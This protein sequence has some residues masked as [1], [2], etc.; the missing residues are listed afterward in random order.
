[1]PQRSQQH[2]HA[3][4]GKAALQTAAE[5]PGA[6]PGWLWRAPEEPPHPQVSTCMP[7]CPSQL[8]QI[9]RMRAAV[10]QRALPLS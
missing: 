6:R 9:A 10:Y 4:Q 5:L 7:C 8:W 1:M 3:S 2:C